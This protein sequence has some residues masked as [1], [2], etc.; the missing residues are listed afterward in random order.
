MMDRKNVLSLY[1][2]EKKKNEEGIKLLYEL[3]LIAASVG[4]LSIFEKL[5]ESRNLF[6]E[7]L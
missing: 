1:E 6:F 7:I 3:L 4:N 5:K 2:K